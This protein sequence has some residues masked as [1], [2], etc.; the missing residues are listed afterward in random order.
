MAENTSLSASPER[1][2]N[3]QSLHARGRNQDIEVKIFSDGL[4]RV[5]LVKLVDAVADSVCK[6]SYNR[7]GT[8]VKEGTGFVGQIKRGDYEAIGLFTNNH[9]FEIGDITDDNFKIKCNFHRQEQEWYL[10]VGA[11]NALFTCPVLDVTFISLTTG[12]V[13]RSIQKR[14]SGALS[15]R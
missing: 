3:A 4:F 15:L 14:M 8:T 9:V 5:E 6:V 13:G 12:A 10:A 1:N 7:R 2:I 11:R